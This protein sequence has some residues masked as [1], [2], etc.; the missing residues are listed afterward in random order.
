MTHAIRP[1]RPTRRRGWRAVMAI[2]A[3]A[4]AASIPPASALAADPTDMVLVWN[5][6]AVNVI[7]QPATNTPPGLGQGPPLAALHVAMVHGA[8]YDA[9]TAIVGGH[10]PYL[11]WIDASCT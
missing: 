10:E 6:N 7:S 11:S 2:L 1:T 8:I 9:V 5:E 4:A 3:I